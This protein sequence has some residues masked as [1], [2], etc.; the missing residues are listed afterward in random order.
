[1]NCRNHTKMQKFVMIFKEKFDD[2]H[3]KDETFRKVRYQCHYTREL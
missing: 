2:E 1:M 3:T